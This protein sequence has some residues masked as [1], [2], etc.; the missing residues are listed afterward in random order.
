[1]AERC[2]KS[3]AQGANKA[4]RRTAARLLKDHWP[5]RRS[6]G[7]SASTRTSPCRSSCEAVGVIREPSWR[8]QRDRLKVK[9]RRVA[10]R[11]AGAYDE[12]QIRDCGAARWWRL[13]DHDHDQEQEQDA[14]LT[15]SSFFRHSTFAL[16]H[17]FIHVHPRFKKPICQAH[18]I[19]DSVTRI[20]QKKSLRT[21]TSL[22]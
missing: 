2:P 10:A 8:D 21:E 12:F 17:F 7:E 9:P 3:Q 19:P 1:V 6:A 22:Q 4:R 5:S 15:S 16:R 13:F 14:P 11:K 20:L 18:G